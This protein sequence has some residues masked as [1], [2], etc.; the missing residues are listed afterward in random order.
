MR[1]KGLRNYQFS[2]LPA[3]G[4]YHVQ[5]GRF[6]MNI[7]VAVAYPG[8]RFSAD[9][10]PVPA[11]PCPVCAEQQAIGIT[12]QRWLEY[13][14]KETIWKVHDHLTPARLLDIGAQLAGMRERGMRITE[15]HL[16]DE[17]AHDMPAPDGFPIPVEPM[18][19]HD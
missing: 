2:V 19:Y 6:D 4:H 1:S 17:D 11:G 18:G 15:V 5:D 13:V 14:Y 8:V 9:I 16:Y 3:R 10:V 7:L 12:G